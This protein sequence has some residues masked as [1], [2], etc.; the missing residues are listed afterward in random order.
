MSEPRRI[1]IG[2]SGASGAIYGIRA[3]EAVRQAGG[4]ELHVVISAGAKATIEYETDRSL[5][6][7]AALAD[8]VH[9]EK[10]LAAPIASGTFL[11]QA[12]LVA[13][14]S[15]RTLSGI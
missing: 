6:Q 5:A 15:I 14:C 7:V 2:I 12:M 9:D 8:V 11:T 10:D 4:I 13:P 3:L 1:V